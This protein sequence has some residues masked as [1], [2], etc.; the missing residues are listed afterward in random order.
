MPMN[1][2]LYP[3]NWEAIALAIKTEVNWT[4]EECGRPCRQT[5]ESIDDF[6]ERLAEL[7]PLENGYL[8]ELYEEYYD[9]ETGEWGCIPRPQRFVLTVAHLDHR[10]ENC[11]RSN[12]KALCSVCHCRYDLKAMPL[13]KMLK[14]EREGQ[15]NLFVGVKNA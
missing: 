14:R 3:P 5:G 6:A 13:K 15:L 8:A 12:L 2:A 10:P 7:D 1:R 4:C 11:D 9:L